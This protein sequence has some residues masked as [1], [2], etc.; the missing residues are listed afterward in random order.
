VEKKKKSVKLKAFLPDVYLCLLVEALDPTVQRSKQQ[1]QLLQEFFIPYSFLSTFDP[2]P[3]F[4]GCR[5]VST[6]RE[7]DG[8]IDDKQTAL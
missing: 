6:S 7:E 1:Q 2:A 8:V 3:H 5:V 4:L